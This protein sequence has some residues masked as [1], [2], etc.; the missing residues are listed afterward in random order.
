LIY[1]RGSSTLCR[2]LSVSRKEGREISNDIFIEKLK[3]KDEKA[4]RLLI[5]EYG[6]SIY[7]AVFAILKD[8]QEAEDATQEAFIKI[9]NSLPNYQSL[10]LKTWL[11]RIAVNH[12]IDMKRKKSR[13]KEDLHNEKVDKTKSSSNAV[14]PL[15]LK[16]EQHAAIHKKISEIPINYRE[17]IYAFY[18]EE[19]THKE[20]AAQQEVEVKTIETKLYR[21][22]KWLK[23][24]WKEEDFS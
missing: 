4:F 19:K 16:N 11:T 24:H 21:A 5:E 8:K 9:Y 2:L 12:A 14:L 20:I 3:R 23:Q 6:N 13:M 18:I 22:R 1:C 15:L 17:V 10:G 7:K